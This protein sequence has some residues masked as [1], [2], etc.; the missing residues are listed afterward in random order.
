MSTSS[1]VRKK[2]L[3]EKGSF[4]KSPFSRDS[5]EFRDSRDSREPPDCGKQRRVR[6]SSRDSR[7]F[8]DFRDS[9]DSSSEKTPFVMTPFSGPEVVVKNQSPMG[10]FHLKA[11]GGPKSSACPSNP[12]ATNFLEKKGK[13]LTIQRL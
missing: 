11:W 1:R 5:R 7:E 6:P 9:R 13:V 4:Q 10:V 12:A 3:L 2:G 8:R